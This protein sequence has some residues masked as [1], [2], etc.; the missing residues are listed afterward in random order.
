MLPPG[1][2]LRPPRPYGLTPALAPV[3]YGVSRAGLTA[4]DRLE[5]DHDNLRA[6]MAW[7]LE[8]S[9]ADPG[10]RGEGAVI[11]LR[12]VQALI[13][14]WYQHEHAT[15]GRQWL[16]RAMDLASVDG[17]APLARVAHGLGVLL[18]QQSESDAALRLFERSL[19]IWRELGD[20][21]EQAREL[22]S[23][24]IVQRHLGNLD[25][26]RSLLEE[27]IAIGRE[28]GVPRLGAALANLGQ[29]KSG[30][31]R[32][33][34]AIEVLQEALAVD[35]Q[36]GDLF[37]VAV[38]HLARRAPPWRLRSAGRAGRGAGAQPAGSA[39]ARSVAQLGQPRELKR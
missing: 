27:A 36:H 16:Q 2:A 19:A 21:E 4:L 14:F 13:P 30:A 22:N 26:G 11:G 38:D 25:T 34:R 33:D 29:L 7:S 12:L 20:R 8:T 31:G 6:A 10:G 37:G 23:P 3:R 39:R 9:A 32:L 1:S 28:L 24:G 17:G 15:E 35:Q 18:D 5:A